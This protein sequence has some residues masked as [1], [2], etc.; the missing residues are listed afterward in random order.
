MEII[1]QFKKTLSENSKGANKATVKN[2]VADV[3]KFA[4][5]F[6]TTYHRPFPPSALPKEVVE[7]YLNL[8]TESAPRSAKRYRSSLNKFFSFLLVNK[9]LAYNPLTMNSIDKKQ[10]DIW[11]LKEFSNF[12]FNEKASPVTI[13]NYLNDIS[14]FLSWIKTVHETELVFAKIDSELIEA[15]KESLVIESELSPLSVN[16]KLSSLRKF[17]A[18]AHVKGYIKTNI[19]VAPSI[20][21]PKDP[22]QQIVQPENSE[23]IEATLAIDALRSLNPPQ[24]ELSPNDTENLEEAARKSYS[25]FA[26]IRLY[27]KSKKGMSILFDTLVIL[28][29]LKTIE[30]IKY[31]FWKTTGKE[32]FAPLPSVVKSAGTAVES[33]KDMLPN[34]LSAI[35]KFVLMGKNASLGRIKGI[36]KINYAPHK[37]SVRALPLPQKIAFYIK[38]IRPKW[39]KRYHSYAFVH[40]IH[41]AIVLV[42]S[43]V[44]GYRIYQAFY[45]TDMQQAAFAS[46]KQ[47]PNRTISFQGRLSDASGSPITKDS[48]VR[49]AIYKSPTASGAALLWQETQHLDPDL[50]GNFKTVLG[51]SNP[52]SQELFVNHPELF[53]GIS[54]GA[55]AELTPRHPLASVGLSRSAATLQGLKPIT[56]NNTV[57]ANVILALDSSGN[58]TIGGNSSP[59]FQATGGEFTL[60]G[61]Q[62][63]LTTIPGSNTNIQLAP[64]GT[65][66]IDVQKPLQNTSEHNNLTSALGAVEVDDNF[67]ILATSSAQSALII[68]QNGTGDIISA[69]VGETA[70]FTVSNTGSGM[71]GGDL[72]IL[73]NNFTTTTNTF[74]FANDTTTILNIGGK[75][76]QVSI[77]SPLGTT[78][79]NNTLTANG[80]F[81]LPVGK[82]ITLSEF[83]PGSIPF[84]NSSNHLTQDN[85]NFFW[86][87][88]NSRLGIG[89]NTPGSKLTIKGLAQGSGT[90]LVMD[91]N[92]NVL[93]NSSSRR[94]KEGIVGLE[95]DFEKIL[96]VQPVSFR[97]IGTGSY[98]I[99]YIAED[100][101]RLGLRD[102]VIYNNAGQPDAIK[103]DRIALYLLEIVKKQQKTIASLQQ[104]GKV[105]DDTLQEMQA[106]MTTVR[107][108]ALEAR[109]ISVSSLAIAT[110]D[111]TIGAQTLREYVESIVNEVIDRRIAERDT[112]TITLLS[113]VADTSPTPTSFPSPTVSPTPTPTNTPAIASQSATYIT[114]IYNNASDITPTA[115]P[116]ATPSPLPTTE[117]VASPSAA[118]ATP[119]PSPTIVPSPASEPEAPASS[120]PSITDF[121]LVRN[122][123][124]QSLLNRS[125]DIASFSA[126][127]LYV[128]SLKSDFG[129]FNYGLIALGPTSLAETSINSKLTIGQSMSIEEN[130]INSL[131][132]DLSLQPLR[133]GNLSIMGGL[134]IID[135]QGNLTVEG[136]ATFAKDV[137]V[138]GGLSANI[139]RPVPEQDLVF[140]LGSK[141]GDQPQSVVISNKEGSGV[142]SINQLGEIIASGSAKFAGLKIVRG[143]QADTS[144]TETMAEG[145]AGTAI[146]TAN[147]TERTIITPHVSADS[148]IYITA[149]SDTHGVTPYIA[150]QTAEDKNA[151]VRGSFTI[152]IPRSVTSDIKLNWWVI[153]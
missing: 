148:L 34:P 122:A 87:V 44:L 25:R 111:V 123:A 115:S 86:D 66:I 104:S 12:L 37:I 152:Q 1:N 98:D 5:W 40:Y 149:V 51:K 61:Q 8:Y 80:G 100:L 76:T 136:N 18:W 140:G 125:V 10:E 11:H 94:Y 79:I 113:P 59:I 138:R 105:L 96:E 143:A 107:D 46:I 41:F 65:G 30:A 29:I 60:A 114:N 55:E 129:T 77:G 73:G 110:E 118:I 9:I 22:L 68:N 26:P 145:S 130:G 88:T 16:R 67:A 120:T 150:R 32:I 89:T 52:I 135:I 62:L 47:P 108:G 109:R 82:I 53:L 85:A 15:Y 19:E 3:K 4:M 151:G 7:Y 58:L 38:H 119:T 39:Y 48:L 56:E 27:Q 78:T 97:Y 142:V 81:T 102:L 133:Q 6:Q 121:E 153:N 31:N 71:F 63:T 17:V 144:F 93:Q 90:S 72:T 147:E 70:K 42:F 116:S 21:T 103:Y 49:F 84:I 57:T 106:F 131:T 117:P 43:V 36:S 128:P 75:A 24:G 83:V 92:G 54:V 126:E 127:L 45:G 99:G 101:D 134:V 2:Y 74:N 13:K 64:D 35:E 50:D 14:Q 141:Q 112:K 95:T 69:S 20:N 28:S 124:K 23:Q 132:G 146:L 33:S 139:I 91:A 137:T